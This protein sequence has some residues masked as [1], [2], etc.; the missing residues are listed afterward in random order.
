MAAI[1]CSQN[2]VWP[3]WTFGLGIWLGYFFTFVL[4]LLLIKEK[5]MKLTPITFVVFLFSLWPFLV[6][7]LRYSF[8]LSNLFILLAYFDALVIHKEDLAKALSYV[9]AFISIVV[10]ISLPFWLVHVFIVEFP[11]FGTLDLSQMKGTEYVYENHFLFVT[12]AGV[13]YSRFYS[14]FDEP[15]VLGTLSAFV[16]LGN[17]YK[18]KYQTAIIFVGGLFTYSMAFYSLT[19]LGLFY[20][21]LS[22]IKKFF[23]LL[24]SVTLVAALAYSFLKDD[25]AFQYSVLSRLESFGFEQ[26]EDRTSSETNKYWNNFKKSPNV[27]WGMGQKRPW[28]EGNSYKLFIIE[29]GIQGMLVLMLMYF[30]LQKKITRK[31]LFFYL[32]F[33]LSFLQRPLAF[34]AWQILLFSCVVSALV[35]NI[36]KQRNGAKNIL[37]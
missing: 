33:F 9:T 12:N 4:F 30:V 2:P 23:S 20:Y 31:T 19:F 14:M 16:L 11:E 8:P 22:S 27:F 18:L 24:V 1:I 3:L 32:F 13:G 6:F 37:D 5:R 34:R 10:S 28:L 25:L 15:G 7:P 35:C 17:K 36:S 26:V 29:Y 21:S